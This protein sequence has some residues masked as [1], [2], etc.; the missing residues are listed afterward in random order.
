MPSQTTFLTFKQINVKLTD[1]KS[2]KKIRFSWTRDETHW[3]IQRGHARRT[4]PKGLDSFILTCKIFETQPP[5][6]STPPP[7]RFTPPLREILDPP[8]KLVQILLDQS[9]ATS[10]DDNNLCMRIIISALII[11]FRLQRYVIIAK[12]KNYFGTQFPQSH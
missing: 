8:L 2:T 3:R 11:A 6:E 12:R 4:P 5:R 9:S 7:T 10:V 1:E